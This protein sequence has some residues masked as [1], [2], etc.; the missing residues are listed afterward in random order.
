[1]GRLQSIENALIAI[2]GDKFQEL[3]DAYL[4]HKNTN[5]S[6]FSRTGSVIGK[7]KS[8][9]GTPD[10]FKVLPNGKFIFVEYSTNISK[11]VTKLIED[12]EKCL[13][14]EKTTIKHEEIE[15]IILCINF[16]LDSTSDVSDL[17]DLVNGKNI[18]LTIYS[19]DG[20]A[21]DLLFNHRDLVFE[22]LGLPYDTGQIVSIEKFIE[23][24]NG[25]SNSIAT[26]LDNIFLH[27]DDELKEL[28]NLLINSDFIVL[29]GAPGVGKTKIAIEAINNFITENNSYKA[30]C[31]SNKHH[32]LLVDLYQY[33]DEEKDYIL[34]VDDAN[35]IDSFKEVIGFYKAKRSGNLKVIITVRNYAYNDILNSCHDFEP[36]SITIKKLS[37]KEIGDILET[38]S[39]GIN[40]NSI[41]KN[42]IIKI[43]DG[44]PRLAIMAAILVKE[45]ESLDTLRDA[46]DLF[47]KYFSTFLKDKKELNEKET[48]KCLGIISFFHSIPIKEKTF[49]TTI[50]ESFDLDYHLFMET[51]EK[52]ERIE[53]VEVQYDSAKIPEQNLS[54]YF[55]YKTFIKDELLSFEV[56]LKNY[57]E[58][59]KHRFSDCVIPAYSTFDAQYIT[60]KLTPEVKKYWE[61]IKKDEDKVYSFL[62]VFWL[63]IPEEVLEFIY[64]KIIDLPIVEVDDYE[65]KYEMNEFAH[66]KNWDIRVLGDLF[67]YTKYLKDALNI[68]FEYVIRKPELSKELIHEIRDELLF[69]WYD[70]RI[71]FERQV[72]L[73][74]LL[75]ENIKNGSKLSLTM[76]YE[77][78][79]S[80][81]KYSFQHTSGTRRKNT[82]SFHDYLI[83][84]CE[85]IDNFRKNI[86]EKIDNNFIEDKA[87]EMLEQ[88]SLVRDKINNDIIIDDAGYIVQIIKN[89]LSKSNFRHCCYVQEQIRQFKRNSVENKYFEDLTKEFTNNT[90]EI[91]S[92]INWDWYRD[93]YDYEYDSYDEYKN[94][95]EHE[96]R[97][98]FVFKNKQE[99]D[100]FYLSYAEIQK[101]KPNHTNGNSLD[102]I[103]EENF[104]NNFEIGLSFLEKIIENNNEIL[105]TPNLPYRNIKFTQKELELLLKLMEE[106]N[107]IGK[108]YWQLSLY[109]NLD[110]ELI[111]DK[112]EAQILNIVKC[113]DENYTFHFIRLSKYLAFF[114]DLFSDILQ[115]IYEKNKKGDIKIF[116]GFG[117]FDDNSNSINNIELLKKSYLQQDHDIA[118]QHFDYNGKGF[119]NILQLDSSF[120]YEYV[121]GIYSKFKYGQSAS[122]KKL[123]FI[124][125]IENIEKELNQVFDLVVSK[126][127]YTGID[128][129]FCNTFFSPDQAFSDRQSQFLI[130]YIE[131]NIDDIKKI[132]TV[133]DIAK[134][135]KRELFNSILEIYLKSTPSV[136][137]FM[138]ISWIKSGGI[139]SGDVIVDYERA[140]EWENILK[141]VESNEKGLNLFLIKR[142]I[143]SRIESYMKRGN[144]EKKWKYLEEY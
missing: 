49:V 85:S 55:F 60:E 63:Y 112:C 110:S 83:P 17:Y 72:I 127:E 12:V 62:P 103:L 94:L 82:I 118:H 122:Y 3:S 58:K 54:T 24:Y 116:V 61:I 74:E 14:V 36:S 88:F 11:G 126:Q 128:E 97:S 114:P 41:V 76:F 119:L 37:D 8:K 70:G 56:L 89:H 65:V 108:T 59:F 44:N 40:S 9:T 67:Q 132:D 96:I 142:A 93:K 31:I 102:M 53:M 113:I 144:D 78:A 21:L 129:G 22:Y 19:I 107:F 68:S 87:I 4:I 43:A 79:Q 34:F 104:K 117:L 28:D 131:S 101:V 5:Y 33:F 45:N 18:T 66:N 35:R 32:S 2:N 48:L 136:E 99:T 95:K 29:T 139:F 46:S 26:P 16:R 6:L 23:D 64:N 75:Y 13:D 98:S 123:S 115:V 135:S 20:I 105:Y 39:F 92:K 1:M 109:E 52:L 137:D 100:E 138:S 133:V 134:N 47:D 91:F 42:D 80:F 10:S 121:E 25:S 30:Y 111:N 141:V 125:Q 38:D 120:L 69:D 81:L 51:I 124:W 90:Y 57:F 106:N 140:A 15:E 27:R 71:N 130:K 50:L 84:K 7:Q 73:F 86:W 77:L 143:N